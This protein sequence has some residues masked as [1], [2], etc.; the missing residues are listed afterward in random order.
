MAKKRHVLLP[1]MGH[2][3]QTVVRLTALE[4]LAAPLFGA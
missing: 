3:S 4:V 2:G 1:N